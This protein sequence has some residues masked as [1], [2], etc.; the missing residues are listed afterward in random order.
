MELIDRHESE[1]SVAAK[2][3]KACV[4]GKTPRR[5]RFSYSVSSASVDKLNEEDSSSPLSDL[6]S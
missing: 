4:P 2:L 1:V 3:D 5:L 6:E